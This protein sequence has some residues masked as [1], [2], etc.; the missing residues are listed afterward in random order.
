MIHCR[1]YLLTGGPIYYPRGGGKDFIGIFDT[2]EEAIIAGKYHKDAEWFHVF[3]LLTQ[4]EVHSAWI[5]G[6]GVLRSQEIAE[7]GATD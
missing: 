1:R 5:D 6:N 7:D 4:K 3:D 2:T